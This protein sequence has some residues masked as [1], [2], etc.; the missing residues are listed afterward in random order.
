[1]PQLIRKSNLT[2]SE[3]QLVELLQDLDFGR[4]EELHIRDG[5]PV[6]QPMPRVVATRRLGGPAPAA[7][8]HSGDF[9]L[10]RHH[11]ELFDLFRRIG[12]GTILVLQVK[13]GLPVAVEVG[14]SA[15]GRKTQSCETL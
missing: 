15:S 6:F 3:Q 10:K 8:V 7:E 12:K 9:E 5:K 13:L 11:L 14:W 1:M 4:V 2:E